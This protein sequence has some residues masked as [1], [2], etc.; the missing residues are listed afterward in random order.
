MQRLVLI[1]FY[2]VMFIIIN[3]IIFKLERT[4]P[5]LFSH[6]SYFHAQTLS[7]EYF[8]GVQRKNYTFNTVELNTPIYM[9]FML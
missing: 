1:K 8:P 9:L 7:Y 4:V 5:F 2:T 3:T 6:A